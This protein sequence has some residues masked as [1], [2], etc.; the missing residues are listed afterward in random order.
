M[1]LKDTFEKDIYRAIDPVVK[2]NELAH[3]QNELEEFVLTNEVKEYLRRFLDAY[4]DIDTVGN[5]SW[6]SGFFGSG[7]SHLLKI[8]AVIL[9]DRKVGDKGAMD[10]ILPKI[11]DNPSLRSAFEQARMKHPAESVLFN[12]DSFAPNAGTATEGALLSAFI[13]AFNHHCGYFDGDQQHI[14]KLEY[15]LDREGHLERFKAR[16]EELCGKPWD[17]VRSGSLLYGKKITQAFDEVCGNPEGTTDNVISYYQKTYEPDI[18]MFAGRVAD[19][20]AQHEKGFRLNFFVD[21]VGQFIAANT[22]LMVNLQTIAE[23]LDNIC[24]GD[25]WVVVTSQENVEDIV[26]QMKAMSANDFS[27]IKD[28]FFIRK[29]LESSGAKEV[30]RDRLLAKNRDNA[31]FIESLYED[32]RADFEVLFDFAEGAKRYKQ[33]QDVQEFVSTY[34]FVPYQFEVF[35]TA[36]RGLSDHNCFTGRHNSTGARSMLGVFQLVAQRI[37]D[38]GASTE[39]GTLAPFDLMFEGLRNDLKSEVYAAISTAESQL[40][41][42]T[43]VRLLKALL[44]VKYCQ[45][46]RATP[47]NLRVLLY[48]AFSEST[49]ELNAKI[50]EALD[51]LERQVYVRRNGNVYEYLTNDEKEVEKEIGNTIVQESEMRDLIAS[52][53]KD[54]CGA[55]KVTYKD[56]AFEHS[57]SYNLK[58]D[59]EGQGLQKYDLTVNIA[60]DQ[61]SDQMFGEVVPTPPKTLTIALRD[62]HDFIVGVR[63]FKQTERYTQVASGGS[64]VRAT[65]I[66]DKQMANGKLYARLRLQIE[67]LLSNASFNAGGV[68][69]TD[70]VSGTSASAVNS[71]AQELVRRSY[72][73]LQQIGT[74]ITDNDVYSQCVSP[75]MSLGLPE[76]CETVLAR[77]RLTRDLGMTTIAGDGQTSLTGFFTKNEFGW[78]EIAVRSAVACLYAANKVEVR[79]AGSAVE[80]AELADALKRKRDLDKLTV[81]II[82]EVSVDEIA[83]LTSSYRAFTGTSPKGTDQKTIALELAQFTESLVKGLENSAS[84]AQSFPFAKEYAEAL[85]ALRACA[86]NASDWKWTLYEFPG[87]AEA[88]TAAK[89]DLTR[90]KSFVDGSP[91]SARW[92]ELC[93]FVA[94]RAESLSDLGLA[95]DELDGIRRIIADP[96]CFKSGEI[97]Q[98]HKAMSE[99]AAKADAK[100]GG[101]RDTAVEALAGYRRSYEDT[102]D[103]DSLP[104]ATRERFAGLFDGA[105][106]NLAAIAS[107]YAIRSFVDDFKRE[108]A[109]ALLGLVEPEPKP[110][111]DAKAKPT[112]EP[113]RTAPLRAGIGGGNSDGGQGAVQGGDQN[114]SRN[115]D[116]QGDKVDDGGVN[117]GSRSPVAQGGEQAK[118]AKR[119]IPVGKLA[120]AGY[121]KPSIADEADAQ[122][123]VDALK[124]AILEAIAAGDIVVS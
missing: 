110:D 49:Q 46:F 69:V 119:A 72:T 44:L 93:A 6:I 20:I 74:K 19:Y 123:Y 92:S 8:M 4:N 80:G 87:Q 124:A 63:T 85:T 51:V 28:R 78:P 95:G 90:M 88:L 54:V 75:A 1:L 33:Y 52:L 120:V 48:G 30:I 21:E 73:G 113:E 15:D 114:G 66:R 111:P 82:E 109:A 38:A 11:H 42:A 32:Y 106:E 12:I 17:K 94:S 23:E 116:Q 86:E 81:S 58:I 29:P 13:K 84:A 100:I 24:A 53:F 60:T 27:K 59:G 47:S 99:L 118:R 39:A 50:A 91:M 43:A 16:A 22:N 67:D 122:A 55:S 35:M 97:P 102:Y 71:A 14:A 107:P 37:C 121:N 41:N 103:M 76:Y 96:E 61:E 104:E 56:G 89:D 117:Q 70:R 112:S 108:N 5:G 18:R 40:D 101:L 25:S 31:A 77:I 64:E 62:S 34:P 3:L 105:A 115:G 26:G 10:Y 2:A 83:S 65:I 36:L 98:A 68:D 57:Y 9:E 7:K 79:K 45:D